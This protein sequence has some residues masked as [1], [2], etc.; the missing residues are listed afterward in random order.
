[1][2]FGWGFFRFPQIAIFILHSEY[3]DNCTYVQAAV[4]GN[5]M[6]CTVACMVCAS[7]FF[8]ALIKKEP[9]NIYYDR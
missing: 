8:A 7:C 3:N 4:F 5:D 1:M 2:P 6:V 9:N